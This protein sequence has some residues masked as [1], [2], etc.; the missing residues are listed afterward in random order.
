[1]LLADLAGFRSGHRL[2][3]LVADPELKQPVGHQDVAGVASVVLAHADVLGVDADDSVRSHPA[4]NPLLAVAFGM[5]Q[6]MPD[7]LVRSPEAAF[8]SGVRQRLV[9]SLRVVVGHPL[10]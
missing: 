6:L 4:R 9:R 3:Q 1:M 2:E 5:S 10:I 8:R 7:L